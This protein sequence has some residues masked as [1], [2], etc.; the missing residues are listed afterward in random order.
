[1]DM[2]KKN[3]K[4]I[5]IAIFIIL[6]GVI[7]RIFLNAKIGIPN[8]EAVT[9]LSL[10]SGSFLGGIYTALVPL[11]IIFL[12][13]IYFGNTSILIFT[14]SAFMVIGIFG[15]FLRKRKS[16]NFR[17]VGQM[18]GMG[19]IASL[20]FYLYTNFGWWLL[21]NFYPHTWQGLINCYIMG[22]PFFKTNLLGNLFFVPLFTSLA[23][24]V[25]KYYPVLKFKFLNIPKKL[26]SYKLK[27]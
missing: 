20:F 5:P 15:W 7:F 13:D 12:S 26:M 3:F 24:V 6:F 8:F 21:T 16:F 2:G 19:I 11:S 9:A 17:F 10:L 27:S 25:W 4:Q 22:L 23:L 14:W 1:M 18:T